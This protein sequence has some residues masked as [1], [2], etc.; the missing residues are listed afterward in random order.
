MNCV[1]DFRGNARQAE[2][3]N[4][5]LAVQPLLRPKCRHHLFRFVV[6]YEV[7]FYIRLL[8]DIACAHRIGSSLGGFKGFRYS[9]RDVLPEIFAG[10]KAVAVVKSG[11][12][13]YFVSSPIFVSKNGRS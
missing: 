11:L 7:R 12:R 6:G 1:G 9:K 5:V 2:P 10:G 13:L 8:R 4:A 3:A